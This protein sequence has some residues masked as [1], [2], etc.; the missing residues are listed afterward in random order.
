MPSPRRQPSLRERLRQ[1]VITGTAITIPFILTVIVLGFVLS[2]VAQT[3]NPVVWLA[4]Y[5]DVEVAPAIVQVTTVLTLLVLIVAV[6]IVAEHTDGTR[7]EGGFHAAMESIPG[8]SSIYNSFRRMSDILLES[9]VE[10]FQE[11]KL[12]EFPRDGSYTLAYLTGRPPA[13]L[14]AATGHEEMLTLFVPF[15]PN[16]VMGGFLIYA[17]EDRVIDVEMSVEESVQAIITSGVAH[18]QEDDTGARTK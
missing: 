13:E 1:S 3:L 7:V 14:V 9:D 18:S 8:V 11:V 10:S 5:L 4:D 17:P 12:V 2:F 6:G 15:A 16:P